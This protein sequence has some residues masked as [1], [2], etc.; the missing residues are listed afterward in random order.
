MHA[1]LLHHFDDSLLL[2][3]LTPPVSNPSAEVADQEGQGVV[4]VAGA[5]RALTRRPGK[6][7]AP[8]GALSP[9]PPSAPASASALSVERDAVWQSHCRSHLT[10]LLNRALGRSSSSSRSA[11][12]AC[13][14]NW[15]GFGSVLCVVFYYEV[16]KNPGTDCQRILPFAVAF[17]PLLVM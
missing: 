3:D 7:T 13:W 9:P 14:L 5:L 4:A 17:W 2:L 10:P 11:F 6:D 8:A 1:H 15:R 12:D 16:C